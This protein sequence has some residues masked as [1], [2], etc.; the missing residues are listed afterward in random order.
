M[1]ILVTLLI[2]LIALIQHVALVDKNSHLM[3][4]CVQDLIMH[5]QD[6][7]IGLI[8]LRIEPKLIM[9]EPTKWLRTRHMR[10]SGNNHVL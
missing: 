10:L 4:L 7:S 2:E 1:L 6:G 3:Q 8:D 9:R 5:E